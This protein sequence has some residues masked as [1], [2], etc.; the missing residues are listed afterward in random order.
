MRVP[1]T[2]KRKGPGLTAGLLLHQ[3]PLTV[4]GAEDEQGQQDGGQGAADDRRQG[5]VPRAGGCGRDPHEVHLAG[6]WEPRERGQPLGGPRER[7]APDR[8]CRP[9]INLRI[10]LRPRCHLEAW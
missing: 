8:G 5:R 6:A 3:L 4:D 1:G 2:E 7:P 10:T 9:R